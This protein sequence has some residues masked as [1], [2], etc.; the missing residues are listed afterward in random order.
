VS[1][2]FTKDD[3]G[4]A[5]HFVRSRAP[6]PRDTPNY[7]TAR[8]LAALRDER[9]RLE[10]ER[11]RW[12]AAGDPAAVAALNARIG[13]LEARIGSAEIVTPPAGEARNAIRFSATVVLESDQGVERR[14]QIVG[15]DEADAAAGR[16]AFTAPLARAL[17]GRQVGDIVAMSTLHGEES[18][19]VR[20]IAYDPDLATG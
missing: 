5:V 14:F 18:W 10:G 17:L 8:G 15:V 2:A 12:E 7:V 1:K 4:A 11:S 13:E 6:L 9:V 19:S 16:I 20:A 3:D